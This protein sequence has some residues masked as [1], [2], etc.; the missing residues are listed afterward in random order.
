MSPLSIGSDKEFDEQNHVLPSLAANPSTA[1]IGVEE[2]NAQQPSPSAS[3]TLRP[4]Q[5]ANPAGAN[6]DPMPDQI[7]RETCPICIVDFEEGDDLRVLPCEGHHRFHQLCVDPWLLELST[8]CP[9]CR[10]GTSHL[11]ILERRACAKYVLLRIDF[12]ALQDIISGETEDGHAQERE[13]NA[14]SSNRHPSAQGRFSRYLRFARRRQHP[15]DEPDPTDP[16]MPLAPASGY[17]A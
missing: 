15:M 2:E 7:G 9:I 12:Q 11:P 8:S 13:T 17:R 16:P 3:Y 4:V 10:H 5:V 6:E 14:L 1:Q